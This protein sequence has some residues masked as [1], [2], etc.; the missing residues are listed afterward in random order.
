VSLLEV[1]AAVLGPGTAEERIVDVGKSVVIIVLRD[2]VER[3]T[4]PFEGAF[5]LQKIAF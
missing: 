5:R 4:R 3:S 1:I 2:L